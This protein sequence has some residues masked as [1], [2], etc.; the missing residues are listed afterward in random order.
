[1]TFLPTLPSDN[2]NSE[3]ESSLIP[4]MVYTY[5][6][7]STFLA[8]VKPPNNQSFKVKS[9]FLSREYVSNS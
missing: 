8:N 9:E 2:Q 5:L 1:M 6:S 3:R 7:G 4:Q